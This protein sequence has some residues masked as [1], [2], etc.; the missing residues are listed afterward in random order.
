MEYSSSGFLEVHTYTA[1]QAIPIPELN[2]R[3]SG[4]EEYNRGTDISLLT[5]RNGETDAVT[6]PTP[7]LSF[8]LTPSPAEQPFAKYDVEISGAGYYPKKLLGVSIF[9]GIKSILQLEMIPNND[10]SRDT[11]PPSTSN[12]SIITEQE[13]L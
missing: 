9:P 6:L 10:L 3:I 1:D 7:I 5:D 13:E 11:P 12:Y 2:V 8:S 4:G